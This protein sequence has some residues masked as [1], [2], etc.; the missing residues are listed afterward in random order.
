MKIK[1]LIHFAFLFLIVCIFAYSNVS[2]NIENF[3][4][5]IREYYHPILRNAR[6]FSENVYNKVTI[7]CSNF[8]RRFGIM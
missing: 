2:N 3:T 1:N 7:H 4:P 6:N 8:L 5:K